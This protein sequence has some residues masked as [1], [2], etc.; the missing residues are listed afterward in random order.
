MTKAERNECERRVRAG[1]EL[2][3]SYVMNNHGRPPEADGEEG[4]RAGHEQ[5]DGFEED[6]VRLSAA[7]F[8]TVR[9]AVARMTS[10]LRNLKRL[11]LQSQSISKRRQHHSQQQAR[12]DVDI[13]QVNH[14]PLPIRDP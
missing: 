9:G 7:R 6:L 13:P 1:G 14:Q 4:E 12:V 10:L 3:V 11:S 5:R 2:L 8:M